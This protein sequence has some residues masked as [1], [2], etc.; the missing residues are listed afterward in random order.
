MG[1]SGGDA[2]AVRGRAAVLCHAVLC[3]A[4]LCCAMLCSAL[5]CCAVPCSMSQ[6]NT[7]KLQQQHAPVSLPSVQ[8]KHTCCI[9]LQQHQQH[10]GEAGV[11]VAQAPAAATPQVSVCLLPIHQRHTRGTDTQDDARTV[12]VD[13]IHQRHTCGT[14][15]QDDART[16]AGE[17]R[18][19][20]RQRKDKLQE[21]RSW[22]LKE[23]TWEVL[24]PGA[25]G[26]LKQATLVK[27]QRRDLLFYH[28]VLHTQSDTPSSWVLQDR[29]L[30]LVDPAS[31]YQ[32]NGLLL[33][34]L[35]LSVFEASSNMVGRPHCQGQARPFG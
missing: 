13:V 30:R 23:T 24:A 10:R 27:G 9:L 2:D 8:Q 3:C 12:A 5:L 1:G 28:Q 4:L 19:V 32:V 17:V 29:C 16:V 7:D 22:P 14:D 34:S 26:A 18:E 35:S 21:R 11:L 6:L 15:M 25:R 20:F 31:C 33:I